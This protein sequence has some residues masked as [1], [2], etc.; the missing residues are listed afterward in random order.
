[1]NKEIKKII[2]KKNK[3][4]ITLL[5]PDEK[6]WR[7]ISSKFG[8]DEDK[9][10]RFIWDEARNKAKDEG[11]NY[12]THRKTPSSENSRTFLRNITD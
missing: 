3:S 10:L 11:N 8:K 7:R 1:M 4:K 6:L 12:P 2:H 9:W 5:S